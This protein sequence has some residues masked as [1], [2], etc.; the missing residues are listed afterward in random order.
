MIDLLLPL[1]FVAGSRLLARTV[2][3]RPAPGG[4]VA[5][6]KEVL[7]VGAGNA[8]Q[9]IVR[10]MLAA[11]AAR[12]YTPIGFVDDD[13]H[14]KNLRLHG[15]RVLGTTDERRT[16]SATRSRTRVLIAMPSAPGEARPRIVDCDARKACPSRRSPGLYELIAGD[17]D[18]AGQIRPVQVEDVLGREPVEVDLDEVASYLAGE[19][20]LVT[21][22]GG[23]IGSELC[24][25]LARLGA[26]RLIL[27]DQSEARAVR[28][29]ARARRRARASPPAFPMIADAGSR[30]KMRQ[31]FERYTPGVVFHAAAYK[32]V[33]MM[34][35]NPVEAVKNNVL[36][37]R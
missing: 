15:V 6:G 28:D 35:A 1:A 37:T 22:A 24:R 18:L 3:E 8:A 10:E 23:S 34:E 31:V 11:V 12:S 20:V 14:K 36:A 13:P 27:V 21:G 26:E 29:R 16:C 7:I 32:H 9:L 19:T 2:L 25:Q 5:H 4:L 33:P 30:T 17:L